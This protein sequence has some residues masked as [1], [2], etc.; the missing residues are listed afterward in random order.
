MNFGQDPGQCKNIRSFPRVP[1]GPRGDPFNVEL[2]IA[3]DQQM[4]ENP[5]QR[6]DDKYI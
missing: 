1:G 3:G 6:M 5:I 2:G 4:E